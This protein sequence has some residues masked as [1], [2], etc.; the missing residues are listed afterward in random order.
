MQYNAA[1]WAVIGNA[2]HHLEGFFGTVLLVALKIVWFLLGTFW[3]WPKN[4]P[5]FS[6]ATN[7]VCSGVEFC[8]GTWRSDMGNGNN[9]I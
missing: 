8:A 1:L 5:S 6:P 3:A 9:T 7:K 2:L 4:L